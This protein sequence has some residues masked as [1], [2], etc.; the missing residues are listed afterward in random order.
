MKKS[1]NTW[2]I[3]KIANFG[4]GFSKEI[5]NRC[6][7]AAKDLYYGEIYFQK[8]RIGLHVV[9]HLAKNRTRKCT[10]KKSYPWFP[11]EV[12]IKN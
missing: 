10:P 12:M 3:V 8:D 6:I 5:I 7:N 11:L 2:G 9:L 1:K 4:Y